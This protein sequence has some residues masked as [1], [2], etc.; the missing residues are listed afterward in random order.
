MSRSFLTGFEL[1]VVAHSTR[2]IVSGRA[3]RHVCQVCSKS[4]KHY[5]SL[6]RHVKHECGKEPQF[7]CAVCGKK[8]AH[9]F[10]LASHTV[11]KHVICSSEASK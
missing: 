2:A 6:W 5:A 1:F 11:N 10:S 4:Y 9:K 3:D 8:F 7:A